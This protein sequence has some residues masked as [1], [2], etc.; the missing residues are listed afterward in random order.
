[1]NPSPEFDVDVALATELENLRRQYPQQFSKKIQSLV[2]SDE[3]GLQTSDDEL[4]TNNL[5]Q[6]LN[7]TP[8]ELRK[9]DISPLSERIRRTEKRIK[10]HQ[11][12][13]E[14]E[15]NLLVELR[16][17]RE[18]AGQVHNRESNHVFN[19][20]VV[21]DPYSYDAFSSMPLCS[22]RSLLFLLFHVSLQVTDS[23]VPLRFPPT[24]FQREIEKEFVHLR[25]RLKIE[26]L[27]SKDIDSL[28]KT[29][30]TNAQSR[31]WESALTGLKQILQRINPLNMHELFRLV[32][33]I[34][35]TA[36]MIRG[37]D[38]ILF[39]G[40]TGVGKSTTIHFL[41]G[42]QLV[43]TVVQGLNHL[44]PRKIKNTEARKILTSPCAQSVNRCVASV[45]ID[46]KDVEI[47][48]RESIVLC[49]TPGF[50]DT[51][52]V[53]VDIANGVSIVRAIR[54]CRSVKPVVLISYRSIGDRLDWSEEAEPHADSDDA[55]RSRSHPNFLLSIHK[56]P[57]E[58]ERYDSCYAD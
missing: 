37:K 23:T 32:R 51:R 42:S 19:G 35:D 36:H 6:C 45:T 11:A 49:D 21:N 10:Q 16:I 28:G 40:E 8:F 54:E 24:Q 26:E 39:L 9:L 47:F 1:M 55:K 3:T 38:V 58:R 5:A 48:N 4:S 52:G 53:E 46:P 34:D 18:L 2:A 41:S 22:E 12:E 30:M 14:R 43:Q 7:Q 13:A 31:N 57:F 20:Q 25:D 29:A 33:E 27:E 15:R 17:L 50:E 44:E 56:V